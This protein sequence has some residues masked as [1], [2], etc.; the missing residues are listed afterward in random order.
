MK[1]SQD[2]IEDLYAFT[3][4]H[5]VEHY[6]L[7][8]ELVDHMANDIES[9]WIKQPKLPYTEARDKAFKKFGIFGFMDVVSKRQKAMGKRY[10]KYLWEELKE[11]FT[12]PKLVITLSI[13]LGFYAVLSSTFATNAIIG[14]FSIIA[15][16]CLYKSVQLNRQFKRRKKLSKKKWMLEEMIFKQAGV[17]A[18]LLLSQLPSAH[19]LTDSLLLSP[20]M[21]GVLSLCATLIT[22]W[23]YISF[24]LLPNKAEDLLNETYSEFSL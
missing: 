10:H 21:M 22:L 16:W 14:S 4:L 15:L 12:V 20:T 8:T 18:L 24:E 23:M 3:R 13:W 17:S 2:E 5:F 1:I 7:Q 9:V 11:W 6:D 19:R